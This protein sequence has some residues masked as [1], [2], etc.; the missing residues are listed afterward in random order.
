[1]SG[2]PFE[3]LPMV[4]VDEYLLY[5][6]Q[7]LSMAESATAADEQAEWRDLAKLWLNRAMEIAEVEIARRE[8]LVRPP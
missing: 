8:S 6:G 2:G 4:A 7:C 5:A 1:M 3:G